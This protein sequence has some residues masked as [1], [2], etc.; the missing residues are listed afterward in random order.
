MEG[1]IVE[2]A[3]A[4]ANYTVEAHKNL[5]VIKYND[6]TRAI[7]HATNYQPIELDL[8]LLPAASE[9][10]HISPNPS[11]YVVVPIPIVTVGVPNRNL[12]AFPLEEVSLFDH[13]QGRMVY[14]TFNYKP[15]FVNHSNSDPKQARGVIVDSAMQYIPK[16]GIWK[17]VIMT[18]WDRSKDHHLVK[19][20]QEDDRSGFSMG[21]LVN[22]FVCS[23]CGKIDPMDEKRCDHMK[24]IGELWTDEKRLSYQWCC[25]CTYFENSYI[26]ED[27]QPADPTAFSDESFF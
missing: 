14:Q 13:N 18:M 6:H 24:N 22:N 19:T 27:S 17:I 9:I 11:D 16:Y 23:V 21:A 25:G 20:I 12:Q 3:I 10:Y 8:D 5:E 26:P 1:H 2:G 15:Q 7:V 4:R